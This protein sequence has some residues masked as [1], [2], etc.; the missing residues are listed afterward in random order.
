MHTLEKTETTSKLIII[1]WGPCGRYSDVRKK[2][3][4]VAKGRGNFAV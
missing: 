1:S 4:E 2:P 3:V